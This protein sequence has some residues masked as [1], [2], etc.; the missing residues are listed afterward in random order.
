MQN[1]QVS[2]KDQLCLRDLCLI[3]PKDEMK[4]IEARK[5][6]LLEDSYKWVLNCKDYKDFTDWS[7]NNKH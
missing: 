2:E 7:D 1:L 3:D 6:I 5:D 4:E